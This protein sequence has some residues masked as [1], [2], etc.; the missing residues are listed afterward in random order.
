MNNHPKKGVCKF[1]WPVSFFDS[2][3]FSNCQ[4]GTLGSTLVAD[5]FVKKLFQ[6]QPK[7]P[8]PTTQNNQNPHLS[9]SF[10]LSM[11]SA[12]VSEIPFLFP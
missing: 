1:L 3:F 10:F 12:F 9:K 5:L 11:P 6:F 4:L 2:D 8:K 7:K